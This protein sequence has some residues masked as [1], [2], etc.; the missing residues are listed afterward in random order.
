MNE[1]AVLSKRRFREIAAN[2]VWS[3]EMREITRIKSIIS[4][5]KMGWSWQASCSSP[6]LSALVFYHKAELFAMNR[7]MSKIKPLPSR[8][9]SSPAG[10]PFPFCLHSMPAPVYFSPQL[11]KSARGATVD[12]IRAATHR[13]FGLKHLLF[14]SLAE[15]AARLAQC[16]VLVMRTQPT[17]KQNHRRSK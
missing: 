5:Q 17:A 8:G 6:L 12:A 7:R 3:R 10:A 14:G 1:N 2:A 4:P 16:S 11:L 9:S 15:R 13:D